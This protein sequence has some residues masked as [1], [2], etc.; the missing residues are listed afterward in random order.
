MEK[1]LSER[2]TKKYCKRQIKKSL[3]LKKVITR[4]D[5]ILY[6]K[7]KGS[8]NSF[9]G[10]FNKKELFFFF[11]LKKELFSRIICT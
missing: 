4:K 8:D 2:F 9:N 5:D 10:W 6:V 7:W 3:E 1:K 11:F